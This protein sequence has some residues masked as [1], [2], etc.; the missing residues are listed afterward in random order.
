MST[1]RNT[2]T[3]VTD[4]TIRFL[5][6]LIVLG[7]FCIGF[8]G[9]VSLSAPR[10]EL[11]RATKAR[12]LAGVIAASSQ[13]PI[14][15]YELATEIVHASAAAQADPFLVASVMRVE[16]RFSPEAKSSA[17][18]RGLMQLMPR[19]AKGLGVSNPHNPRQNIS[20]GVRY[21]RELKKRYSGNDF[22]ALTAYN[23]GPGNVD[24]VGC[25]RARTPRSVRHYADSILR[26]STHLRDTFEASLGY[27]S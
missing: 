22:C 17:G 24:R 15:A 25:S 12:F 1:Y 6:R 16:S 26:S 7:L 19:T 27:A 2:L 5:N 10:P 13:G 20:G 9:S 11:E 18:A 14:G 21:L 3:A 4:R 8:L 23:W